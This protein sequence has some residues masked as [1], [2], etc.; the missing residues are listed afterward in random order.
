MA[1]FLCSQGTKPILL[2][3]KNVSLARKS[4]MIMGPS[5][6]PVYNAPPRAGE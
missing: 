1:F 3:I 5:I 4:Q 2:F 6:Y